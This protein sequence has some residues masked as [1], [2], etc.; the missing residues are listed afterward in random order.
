MAQFTINVP[1]NQVNRVVNALC[2][3]GGYTTQVEQDGLLVPNPQT[4]AQFARQ[5]VTEFIKTAVTM[6][7]GKIAQGVK[8][9]ELKAAQ[10]L[11]RQDV[12]TL[13]ID[14]Q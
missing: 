5:M 8:Q 3:F 9:E 14:T 6:T 7:E 1:D 12:E 10:E 11:I 2:T 4:K 13:G